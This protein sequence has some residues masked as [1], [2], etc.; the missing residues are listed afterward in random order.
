MRIHWAHIYFSWLM[1]Q[2]P[3]S[4]MQSIGLPSFTLSPILASYG[5]VKTCSDAT[6]PKKSWY[7]LWQF[8]IATS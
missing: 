3:I 4:E 2:G 5:I 1:V 7:V 6:A 8:Q